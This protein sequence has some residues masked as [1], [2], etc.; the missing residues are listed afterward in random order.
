MLV[1]IVDTV[2]STDSVGR[3]VDAIPIR[4]WQTG[5]TD[6]RGRP[7]A[8]VPLDVS[9]LGAPARYVVGK[10][11]VNSAGQVVD[12]IP[13][14]GGAQYNMRSVP[15]TS[16]L[17]YVVAK[18]SVG[19]ADA[20]R[21]QRNIGAAADSNNFGVSWP[22]WRVTG[23]YRLASFDSDP[24]SPSITFTNDTGAQDIV[25]NVSGGRFCG[26]Y[27]GLGS[28]GALNSETLKVDGSITFDPTTAVS[29]N[30]FELRNSTTANDG[31]ASFT[32]DLTTTINALGGV[33]YKINGTPT[34][35]GITFIYYGMAIG[36]GL[37]YQ[38]ADVRMGAAY[39]VLPLGSAGG[40]AYLAGVREVRLRDIV[41]G[42]QVIATG[43]LP[44]IANFS[45]AELLMDLSGSRTKTYL[46]RFTSPA[47]LANAEIDMNVAVGA[48]GAIFG[49]TNLLSNTVFTTGWVAVATNGTNGVAAGVLTQ[50]CTVN[51][52]DLRYHLPITGCA[53]GATY[54]QIVDVATGTQLGSAAAFAATSNTNGSKITPAPAFNQ[55]VVVGRNIQ[56]F[57]ATQSDPNQRFMVHLASTVVNDVVKFSGPG[58][59]AL[60]A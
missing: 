23:R 10:T 37:N 12:T 52:S 30:A 3:P 25:A 58:V 5:E 13:T 14:T 57:V 34:V 20:I 53:I 49:L 36:T 11:A 47:A 35:S 42:N 33:H 16:N 46:G 6:A 21:F 54:M 2:V 9:P 48:A 29:F 4:E 31:S 27:H 28:S 18:N 17:F 38:E 60:A 22:E 7:V 50:T 26:S 40:R 15:S 1:K 39:N 43:S 24:T 32:R 51:P 59:Y 19:T 56:T 44:D 45:R 41:N 8:T 55:G